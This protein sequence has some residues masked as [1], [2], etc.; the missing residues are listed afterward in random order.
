[1]KKYIISILAI[2]LFAAVSVFSQNPCT[3][4][5]I[6]FNKD[7]KN[8][9]SEQQEMYL[10]DA[11]A[12]NIEKNF[13]VI[14]DEAANKYLREIGAKLVK[15][16]PPTNLKF[17]FFIIDSPELNAF[18]TAGG[19]IYVTRKMIAFVRSEAE[20]A[21]ILGHELGHGIVR[22]IA[23][24][25]SK[26]FKEILGVDRVGDRD[27][28]FR[29][30][31]EFI[32]KQNTK[33]VK[34]NRSHEGNQ[35]LEADN[36]GV[37]S[38]IAAGY[39]PDAFSSAWDRLAETEGKTGSSFSDFFGATRP[40][41]KRLREILNAIK[42]VP[43]ECLDKLAL[44]SEKQFKEWQSF[45]ITT[46]SFPKAE[47]LPSLIAKK[48]LTPF[49]RGD[50]RHFRFSPDG[51]YIIAQDASGINVL[52]REPFSFL[53]RID[54][55]DAKFANFSP[56]SKFVTF[57]TFGLRVEKWSIAEKKA[58]LAQEV[59]VRGNCWQSALSPDGNALVCYSGLGNLDIIDVATNERILRKAE[60]YVPSLVEYVTWIFAINEND[61]KEADVLQM[62]FSPDG[63]YF[64]GGRVFR[65]NTYANFR[66][67]NF[68][69]E[70]FIAFDLQERKEI[71][72]AGDIKNIIS[73]PYTFYSK[74]SIVGQH[75]TDP[76]KSG[77]FS[78]PDGK[79]VEKFFLSA[80][81]F[82]KA[83][84]G[85]FLL[86]RPTT[87]NPVG[88]YDL[89]SKKFVG[90]NKTPALDVYGDLSVS[91]SKD[92]VVS[93]FRTIPGGKEA[94]EF[95]SI[96][97]PRNNLG[98]IKTIAISP[99][100]SWI[101]VSGK[102]RG[103]VWSIL[104]GEMKIYIRGFNGSYFGD[105]GLL[106]ADFPKSEN[107]PRGMGAMSPSNG[108]A[109]MLGAIETRNTKQFG[110]YLVR[111][112]TKKDELE[113]KKRQKQKD[114][115]DDPPDA[116]ESSKQRPNFRFTSGFLTGIDIKGGDFWE[117]G[118]LEVYSA[119]EQSLIWTKTFANE[120]PRYEFDDASGTVSFYWSVLTK[121]AKEII[122]NSPALSARMKSLGD[123][124]GDYLVQVL[125][126]DNGNIVNETLIET[127]EGSFRIVKVFASGDW[128][129]MIDSENRV[130]LYSLSKGETVW[131]FFGDNA[132]VN[133]KKAIAVVENG[134]GQ[135]SVYSLLNGKKLD[136]LQFPAS[137][138][139]AD[140]K[141]D[142]NKLF[143]LTA[144]QNYYLFNTEG[145][146]AKSEKY[147]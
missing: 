53:F 14:T 89:K 12:E 5:E 37:F 96:Q 64:L 58:V 1:M 131:R 30:Y 34:T 51:E 10:G 57:Q 3:P 79:R 63:K 18:N 141:D 115:G 43:A 100:L 29:K 6:V 7:P 44:D 110:K 66:S 25:F 113:E 77:I 84:K 101:T 15:H 11:I 73:M 50:I 4:P 61:L 47:K 103:A 86:V 109:G 140:F 70:A 23:I 85:D 31:N 130:Q 19:R 102:S 87:N 72:V 22:H 49:L 54:A 8:I 104:N 60:F 134:S 122:K 46:T 93:L 26:Y 39:H 78:F 32:D 69:Q 111:L 35:Q 128:L 121:S 20:L 144:N 120:F 135:L 27:D 106:F 108:Q 105:N 98:D 67:P 95:S 48:S 143:V 42:T 16:L 123:K 137:V 97:L 139:F 118:S 82:T 145:F 74:D 127:G 81:S 59:F 28:V 124:N 146:G 99:D 62:E 45:I 13:R 90:A 119:M 107:Q 36:I 116:E 40:N 133:S 52:K 83:H 114:K 38:M 125:N 24:D 138:V 91:E 9:F 147:Q 71:K 112:Q 132:V 142:G 92:G 68:N 65:F 41:E 94:E 88:V 76:E 17:Q 33:R 2:P 56:D 75:R 126:A 21:G 129:T 80:E 55:D 117:D 136:E